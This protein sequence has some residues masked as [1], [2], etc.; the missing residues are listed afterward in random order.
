M[1]CGIKTNTPTNKKSLKNPPFWSIFRKDSCQ[2][3]NCPKPLSG[4]GR[5]Q[6]TG[7]E[8]DGP[9]G[10][11]NAL[12]G[13]IPRTTMH[14]WNIPPPPHLTSG[15]CSTCNSTVRQGEGEREKGRGG[16]GEE[17]AWASHH[18]LCRKL[19][20][21]VLT[22]HAYTA[23][24]YTSPAPRGSHAWTPTW[25]GYCKISAIARYRLL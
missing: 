23:T 18:Y 4:A 3:E 17:A 11:R 1:D 20:H 14:L 15:D 25:P 13:R 5:A 21:T 10:K 6:D 22:G 2:P 16:E 9:Q 8:G 19:Y 7:E 24:I 12:P